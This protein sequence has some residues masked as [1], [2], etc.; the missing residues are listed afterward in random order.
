MRNEKKR[1]NALHHLQFFI[2]INVF[3]RLNLFFLC[4]QNAQKIFGGDIKNHLLLF[5]SKSADDFTAKVDDYRKAAETY[6][7]K[8]MDVLSV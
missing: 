1:V 5:V 7:G 8:V 4:I 3:T 6:K 2:N